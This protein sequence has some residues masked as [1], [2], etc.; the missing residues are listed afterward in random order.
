MEYLR[1]KYPPNNNLQ[2]MPD[3][4]AKRKRGWPKSKGQFKSANQRRRGRGLLIMMVWVLMM[5]SLVL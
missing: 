3:F 5:W 2:Y 4:V 1:N